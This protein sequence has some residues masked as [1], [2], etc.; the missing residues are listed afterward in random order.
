MK[1]NL[2]LNVMTEMAADILPCA[3]SIAEEL[4]KANGKDKVFEKILSGI[5]KRVRKIS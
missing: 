5:E 3:R 2:V 1:Q 4:S